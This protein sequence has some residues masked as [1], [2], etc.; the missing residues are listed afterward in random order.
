MEAWVFRTFGLIADVSLVVLY[1]ETNF[2]FDDTL[3]WTYYRNWHR[4]NRHDSKGWKVAGL[5]HVFWIS[6][7]TFIWDHHY[8]KYRSI[9]LGLT[10]GRRS[11]HSVEGHMLRTSLKSYTDLGF[12]LLILESR[13]NIFRIKCQRTFWPLDLIIYILYDLGQH[14]F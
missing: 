8:V 4:V 3:E 11:L 2:V 10:F 9:C 14:Y 1:R 7:H 5:I 6:W 13:S 12:A